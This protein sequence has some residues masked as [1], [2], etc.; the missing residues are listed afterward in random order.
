MAK[1]V[2]DLYVSGENCIKKAVFELD[3]EEDLIQKHIATTQDF[4]ER[5]LLDFV[6]RLVMPRCVF[7][8]IGANLGNHSIFFGLLLRAEIYA[9]EPNRNSYARLIRNLELSGLKSCSH[10]YLAAVG[11]IEGLVKSDL[12]VDINN[13]G[14]AKVVNAAQSD[15]DAVPLVTIDKIFHEL[16][17]QKLTNVLVKID[18]EGMEFEVLKGMQQ[19]IEVCRPIIICEIS[20]DKNV[21]L[22]RNILAKKGYVVGACF[23]K[24]ATFVLIPQERISDIIPHL[25]EPSWL[26]ARSYVEYCRQ[27]AILNRAKQYLTDLNRALFES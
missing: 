27:A 26:M 16:I 18:V 21:V 15:P 19:M 14:S 12:K 23:F 8:D 25:I 9:F 17:Q 4:Y 20:S 7:I 1:Q 11:A 6:S 13:T 24:S 3:N 2:I 10:S 5:P 22:I